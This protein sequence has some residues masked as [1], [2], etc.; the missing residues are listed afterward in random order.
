MIY[1]PVQVL[2]KKKKR[3]GFFFCQG[4]RVA[5]LWLQNVKNSST[6]RR[7]DK[8]QSASIKTLNMSQDRKNDTRC[9]LIKNDNAWFRHNE[10]TGDPVCMF[11]P[12][13]F[14]LVEIITK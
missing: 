11:L 2:T 5:S 10:F 9:L 13:L 6:L 12:F 4:G 1:I 7:A 3:V 14:F 8:K